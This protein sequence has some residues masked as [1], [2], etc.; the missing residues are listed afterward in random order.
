MSKSGFKFELNY[1]GVGELLKSGNMQEALMGAARQ[2]ATSAGVDYKAKTLDTRVVVI[3][4]EKAT[5]DNYENNTLLKKVGG[6]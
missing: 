6:Q 1:K 3:G 2:L 5:Q 4:N